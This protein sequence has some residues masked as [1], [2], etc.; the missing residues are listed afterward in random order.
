MAFVPVNG[1]KLY[2]TEKGEGFPIVFVHEFAGNAN[3]WAPQFR[4][5]SRKYRCIAYNSRGYPPSDV[6]HED[7]FGQEFQLGDLGGLLDA[8]NIEKAHIVGLSMGAYT[9]L[10]YAMRN[11][12]RVY[13]LVAASGG[14]GSDPKIREAFAKDART[15]ADRMLTSWADVVKEM[16]TAP[17]RLQL[18][19]KDPKGYDRFVRDMNEASP[20][21]SAFTMRKVQAERPSLYGMEAELRAMTT[22]TLLIAGD[23]DEACIDVNIFLKRNMPSAGLAMM[24]KAG[25]LV[26]LEDPAAFNTLIEG[27][28]EQVEAGTWPR[29]TV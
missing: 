23:E 25:H 8:L 26:N 7:L 6:P 18:K 2:V 4:R 21:G 11:P 16:T 9:G 27:F 19:R 29:R 3:S 5:L 10:V 14:S 24:P 28:L 22:P 1:V 17:A 20:R 12:G 15:R 13:G